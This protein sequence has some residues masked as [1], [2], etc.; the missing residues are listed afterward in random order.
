MQ[1]LFNLNLDV[2]TSLLVET[3]L[4]TSLFLVAV[5]LVLAV[6]RSASAAT[7][8]RLWVLSMMGMLLIPL[9]L[10]AVPQFALVLPTD[11]AVPSTSASSSVPSEWISSEWV[12][13]EA[14]ESIPATGGTLENSPSTAAG[15]PVVELGAPV[16]G[17]GSDVIPE[18]S[19]SKPAPSPLLI[20]W[21]AGVSI[22]AL[23]SCIS[24]LSAQVLVKRSEVLADEGWQ[25]QLLKLA[26]Q[27][28]VGR[29]VELRICDRRISPMTWGVRRPVILLPEDC[30][31]WSDDCRRAVLL[32]ELAH[33]RRNDWL[34]QMLTQAACVLYWFHPLMWIVAREV[35]KES[36][37]AADDMAL[38]A[39]MSATSYAEQLVHIASQ[40][41]GEWLHPAPAMARR[42]Q[43]SRRIGLL[44]DPRRNR[45]TMSRRLSVVVTACAIGTVLVTTAVTVTQAEP[46]ASRDDKPVGKSKP[47]DTKESQAGAKAKAAEKPAE[48][49]PTV[50]E[51]IERALNRT[52]Q[53]DF[54]DSPLTEVVDYMSHLLEINIIVDETALN[55]EGISTD[56]P[57]T[58]KLEDIT[59]SF[60]WRLMLE[61]LELTTLVHDDVLQTTTKA[62]ADRILETRVYDVEQMLGVVDDKRINLAELQAQAV[63]LQEQINVMNS[64]TVTYAQ[65]LATWRKQLEEVQ[66]KIEAHKSRAVADREMLR[67][68]IIACV[69]P[70]TWSESGGP[71][72]IAEVGPKP[73]P[74]QG[75]V[76][77]QRTPLPGI[78]VI[79]QT[80]EVH[81]KIEALLAD[82]REQ[83]Q[84]QLANKGHRPLTTREKNRQAIRQ[85]LS[86]TG[87]VDFVDTPLIEVVDYLSEI[88]KI[89]IV[90]D[91][92]ALNDEGI[93]TDSP[94]TL[95]IDGISLQNILRLT[96]NPLQLRAVMYGEVLL[97]TTSVRAE[98]LQTVLIHDVSDL[99]LEGDF[100][101]LTAMIESTVL[102]KTWKTSGGASVI[103]PFEAL[104]GGDA[105]RGQDLP[106]K[107]LLIVRQTEQGHE[108]VAELL[109]KLRKVRR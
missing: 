33:I 22:T 8:H 2:Q 71:G 52:V 42:G 108:K 57:V 19:L 60:A 11:A 28:G 91:E 94:T 10:V 67:R 73:T 69:D 1:P 77:P 109:E 3:A 13:T 20:G 107:R 92:M 4:R 7:R 59:A 43:L 9:L 96:L 63:H 61:P 95:N 87:P 46:Q 53:V 98:E 6:C 84:P 64:D 14:L 99:R 17:F 85:A 56:T 66:Q 97:I 35:R 100:R 80:A 103:A 104:K 25:Q 54:A 50:R 47:A 23:A 105:F 27:L 72:V 41:A 39:G 49:K 15:A 30:L 34:W 79:R 83:I 24:L 48:L 21:L 106:A 86:K 36:D 38:G 65:R 90:I 16:A 68:A 81:Q 62:A 101:V 31:T 78:L 37:R 58:L 102:P 40:I 29:S 18:V 88:F 75:A 55:D 74:A 51:Q 82:L 70:D 32:H 12:S 44:L 76:A 5:M 89:K 45:R 93:S 26:R